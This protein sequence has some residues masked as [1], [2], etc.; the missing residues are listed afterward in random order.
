MPIGGGGGGEGRAA[1]GC[2]GGR[3]LEWQ[4]VVLRDEM[5]MQD[6]EEL[7]GSIYEEQTRWLFLPMAP[8]L[9]LFSFIRRESTAG[10]YRPGHS[11]GEDCGW[12]CHSL[13]GRVYS[14]RSSR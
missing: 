3:S 9:L 7:W 5:A 12:G 4:R 11:R 13:R 2:G 14:Q 10:P 1:I 6:G 8:T